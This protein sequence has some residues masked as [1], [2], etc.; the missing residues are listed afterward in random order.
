[1]EAR[2]TRLEEANTALKVLLRELE[3][4]RRELEEK[5]VSNLNELTRP[6][7]A[8]L[9]A[10]ELNSRQRSLIDAIV[11]SL[12]DITSPLSRRFII[13]GSKLTPTEAQVANLIRQGKTTKEI[14]EFMG[15]AVSTVDFHRLN[16]R[17]RLKF[18]N[19]Q[20]NLQSYL[21]SLM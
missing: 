6:H 10:G 15:V 12:D 5:M 21:K 9:A 20:I 3:N 19:K 16:I 17:R 14:A 4:E 8:K 18:T 11:N 13:A 7:L 1:M 2:S